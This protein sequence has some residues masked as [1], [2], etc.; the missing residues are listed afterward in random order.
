MTVAAPV[1]HAVQKIQEWL[2]ELQD[3]GEL[4]D[5]AAAYAVLRSVLNRLRDR[6]TVEGAVHLGAQLP[7]I[8]RGLYYEGW[9]PS[10]VP[11][12][13]RSKQKFVDELA[14][15]LLPYTYPVE[16]AV[17]DVFALLAHHCDPNEIQNVIDQLPADIKTLWPEAALVRRHARL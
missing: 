6:L 9:R 17:C 16:R 13:V 8:V 3:K 10:R 11:T 14:E 15:E 4:A 12:K 5:E 7:L 1:G 2:K